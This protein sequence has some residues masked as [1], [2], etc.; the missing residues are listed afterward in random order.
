MS[1]NKQQDNDVSQAPF[2]GIE[3]HCMGYFPVNFIER[4][5][6]YA[7][8][9]NLLE[10]SPQFSD[11]TSVLNRPTHVF[12]SSPELFEQLRQKA[13]E[14]KDLIDVKIVK[15]QSELGFPCYFY[16]KHKSGQ[17]ILFDGIIFRIT[18]KVTEQE[19]YLK[20]AASLM[21]YPPHFK[22][23]QVLNSAI[24]KIKP[25]FPELVCTYRRFYTA[26]KT[27]WNLLGITPEGEPSMQIPLIDPSFIRVTALEYVSYGG[28]YYFYIGNYEKILQIIAHDFY[29]SIEINGWKNYILSKTENA[30]N[31]FRQASDAFVAISRSAWYLKSKFS[32]WHK[33]KKGFVYLLQESPSLYL[34]DLLIDAYKEIA[35]NKLSSINGIRQIFIS[36]ESD[37]AYDKDSAIALWEKYFFQG[38]IDN[39]KIVE[40]SKEPVSPSYAEDI[41]SLKSEVDL[42]KNAV[43]ESL[44]LNK[45]LFASVQTE[46]SAY[47]IWLAIVAIIISAFLGAIPLFQSFIKDVP[48]Q[49]EHQS[50]L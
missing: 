36:D 48:N 10:I 42:L 35:K 2:Q 44:D 50:N 17:E 32:A 45:D 31:R 33:A 49:Q 1:N 41:K 24:R 21:G 22:G 29:Q 26:L 20:D 30:R 3:L 39:N 23:V 19:F 13:I 38:K 27:N 11:N 46:F 7:E 25:D 40:I 43:Q 34:Y 9:L 4:R 16:A 8:T 12:Q 15:S 14:D 47:A 5:E 37:D 18:L 28:Q 6:S